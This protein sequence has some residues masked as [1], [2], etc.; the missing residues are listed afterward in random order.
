[1]WHI[2]HHTRHT[3]HHTSHIKTP[4]IQHGKKNSVCFG[5]GATIH[6]QWVIHRHQY[7]KFFQ[8]NQKTN[9]F[10]YLFN[11]IFHFICVTTGIFYW[12]TLT[13]IGQEV[14]MAGYQAVNKQCYKKYSMKL[15]V[16]WATFFCE[17]MKKKIKR[18][19]NK[20]VK[21][22]KNKTK[23]TCADLL[24]FCLWLRLNF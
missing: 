1:M 15:L 9:I 6:T 21:T 12:V 7:A 8:V 16:L 18:K 17:K 24:N 5:L 3:A 4:L 10:W 23:V 20:V 13:I 22:K 11:K 14:G 19:C 2:T